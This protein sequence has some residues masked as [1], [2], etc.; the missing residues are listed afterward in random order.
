MPE[1]VNP[2]N[3]NSASRLVLN[4]MAAS[5]A[6]GDILNRF[7]VQHESGQ[8]M[9]EVVLTVGGVE[10]P[11]TETID[12]AWRTIH[13]NITQQLDEM[14]A[15]KAMELLG[16][17]ELLEISDKVRDLRDVVNRLLAKEFGQ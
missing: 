9:V 10:V 13:D 4:A 8:P 14:V 12:E 3:D 2:L 11:F 7:N 16:Q 17:T 15:D 5:C 1:K 6:R